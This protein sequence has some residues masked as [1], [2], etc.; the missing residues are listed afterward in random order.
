MIAQKP[1]N[2]GYVL[3]KD[4]LQSETHTTSWRQPHS[5]HSKEL[6]FKTVCTILLRRSSNAADDPISSLIGS[7]AAFELC[8]RKSGETVSEYNVQI[9]KETN[10]SL[11]PV[12]LSM[13]KKNHIGASSVMYVHPH[14]PPCPQV[15]ALSALGLRDSR[16]VIRDRK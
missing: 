6:D 16:S 11:F 1:T 15:S 9:K 5:V 4:E 12:S 3:S 10:C 2:G 13:L 8:R 14:N 7:S